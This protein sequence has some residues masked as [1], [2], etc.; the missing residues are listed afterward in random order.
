M[1]AVKSIFD[2]SYIVEAQAIK[3][4]EKEW[5]QGLPFGFDIELTFDAATKKYRWVK[6]TIVAGK[7]YLVIGGGQYAWACEDAD[8]KVYG[9]TEVEALEAYKNQLAFEADLK[10]PALPTNVDLGQALAESGETLD[11][12]KDGDAKANASMGV[13][14]LKPRLSSVIR[15]TRLV[16]VIAD[17]MPK[18]SRKEVM[19]ECV[20]QGVAYGTART[21]YQAWFKASQEG[22]KIEVRRPYEKGEK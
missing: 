8:I 6:S 11:D 9:N 2:K 4:G 3:A 7:P 13:D 16:W 17:S 15:P 5:P 22:S 10:A 1:K 12:L 18:A 19:A 21:Q 14:A 20:A